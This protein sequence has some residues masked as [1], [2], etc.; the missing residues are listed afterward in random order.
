LRAGGRFVPRGNDWWTSYARLVK[1]RRRPGFCS[2]WTPRRRLTDALK[3]IC[4]W[5]SL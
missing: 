3:T 5:L 2:A 4:S 1:R